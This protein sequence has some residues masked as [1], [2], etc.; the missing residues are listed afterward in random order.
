MKNLV[1]RSNPSYFVH[2]NYKLSV[3]LP[4]LFLNACSYTAP[5]ASEMSSSS[6]PSPTALECPAD[7]SCDRPEGCN[8]GCGPSGCNPAECLDTYCAGFCPFGNV[9][10]IR[11]DGSEA[12]C[13]FSCLSA[14][15]K[16]RCQNNSSCDLG[17]IGGGCTI[18]CESG[19]TCHASCNVPGNP[20]TIV[21]SDGAKATCEGTCNMMGCQPQ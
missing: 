7:C 18:N 4:F 10:E 14:G 3:V 19:S 2:M 16:M 21:C 6:G 12:E 5:S 8:I 1:F 17:C 20:C 11:C 15:C 13:G 9:C